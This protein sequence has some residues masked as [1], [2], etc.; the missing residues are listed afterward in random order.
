MF[1][2][3]WNSDTLTQKFLLNRF[4]TCKNAWH[5]SLTQGILQSSPV[6]GRSGLDEVSLREASFGAPHTFIYDV[7]ILSLNPHKFKSKWCRF[8]QRAHQILLRRPY[9][10]RLWNNV[11]F[12]SGTCRVT[13]KGLVYGG[14]G[15]ADSSSLANTSIVL[16]HAR[17]FSM[18]V[19][20][21]RSM[22]TRQG[23]DGEN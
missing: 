7:E 6:T 23:C 13:Q 16:A 18:V 11:L 10:C 8:V 19:A 12:V 4:A 21:L 2:L 22:P 5:Q 20:W 1:S 15:T 9:P 14:M 17:T 3:N